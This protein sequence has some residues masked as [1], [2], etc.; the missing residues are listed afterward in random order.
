MD[1]EKINSTGNDSLVKHN[2]L[3]QNAR[4]NLSV[5][6]QKIILYLISKIKPGQQPHS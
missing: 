6:E 1:N 2:D 3:I 4:Y 5:Q